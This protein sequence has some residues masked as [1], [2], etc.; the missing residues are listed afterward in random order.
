[1][2]RNDDI[3][4][5]VRRASAKAPKGS[6]FGDDPRTDRQ[7]LVKKDIEIE[8]LRARLGMIERLRVARKVATAEKIKSS[9]QNVRTHLEKAERKA[10]ARRMK[11]ENPSMSYAKIA[12]V[13]GVSKTAVHNYLNEE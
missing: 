5:L 6:L 3:R 11:A 8:V 1:M 13:L 7:R 9:G 4:E 10:S 12:R 2:K